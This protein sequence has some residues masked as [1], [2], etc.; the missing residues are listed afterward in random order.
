VEK[1]G[2]DEQVTMVFGGIEK[3]FKPAK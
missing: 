1:A 3:G 2:A